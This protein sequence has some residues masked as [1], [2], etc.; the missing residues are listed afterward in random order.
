MAFKKLLLKSLTV[1]V[2]SCTVSAHSWVEEVRKI[3]LTGAF[4]GEVGYPAHFVSRN[5]PPPQVFNDKE[6][7]NKIDPDALKKNPNPAV[8]K[9]IA[10]AYQGNITRLTA[11][12][13]DYVAL[14]YQEN[15][16]VTQP[17][18]TV[19]PYRDGLVSIYGTQQH[20]DSD[21]VYDVLNSWTADGT[22]GNG[23]GKLLA[24]HFYDDGQCYQDGAGQIFQER[25]QK[26]GLKELWCQ[27]DFRLPEDLPETGTYTVIWIWDWPLIPAPGQNVTEIYTS[28]IE[29]TLEPKSSSSSSVKAMKFAGDHPIDSAG[30]LSQLVNLYEATGLGDGTLPP[31]APTTTP[32]DI[33]EL[34]PTAIAT[35]TATAD[36]SIITSTA[37]TTATSTKKHHGGVK[38]VTVTAAAETTTQWKT[39]TVGAAGNTLQSSEI[40]SAQSSPTYTPGQV[41]TSTLSPVAGASSSP[42]AI[43]NGPI[44][45]SKFLKAR[46]TGHARREEL[47]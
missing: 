7:Q 43:L 39:V 1:L 17:F 16:H 6:A 23:K 18:L 11:S 28:C 9:P 47:P 35:A 27:S 33:T 4:T 29:I 3:D 26:Y 46:A 45:V 31:A 14:R 44:S 32:Q 30:V 24:T 40:S 38:T 22:G 25:K 15:G 10:G 42:G 19:R 2:A 34:N 20:E 37:D 12:A 13:G 36:A 8:C 21:G 5:P 41:V